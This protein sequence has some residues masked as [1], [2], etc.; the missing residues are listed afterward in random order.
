[1]VDND[2]TTFFQSYTVYTLIINCNKN[3]ITEYS[4]FVL[5]KFDRKSIL[6]IF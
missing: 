3:N 4:H 2:Y 6:S 5:M 1:M